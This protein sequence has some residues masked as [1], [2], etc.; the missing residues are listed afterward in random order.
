MQI[1]GNFSKRTAVV[2]R[3]SS[4]AST[5]GTRISAPALASDTALRNWRR[6]AVI[7]IGNPPFFWRSRFQLAFEL[8]QKPPVGAVGD[9]LLRRRFDEASFAL[10]QSIEPDGVFGV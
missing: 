2:S 8:I 10:A 7:G 4:A 6:V 5:C 3:A 1:P 9:D